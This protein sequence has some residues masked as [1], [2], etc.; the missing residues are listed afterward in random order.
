MVD[1]SAEFG[2]LTRKL[3]GAPPGIGGNAEE[4]PRGR[5]RQRD[6]NPA[7]QT[8]LTG[9]VYIASELESLTSQ[10]NK[11]VAESQGQINMDDTGAALAQ[12]TKSKLDKLDKAIHG[13]KRIVESSNSKQLRQHYD[14]IHKILSSRFGVQTKRFQKTLEKRTKAI[15][16]K[17][18]QQVKRFGASK[19]QLTAPSASNFN[20]SIHRMGPNGPRSPHFGP[21]PGQGVPGR[22][23]GPRPTSGAKGAESG[24]V[25]GESFS[26]RHT[27]D[28]GAHT[29]GYGQGAGFPTQPAVGPGGMRRR[30]QASTNEQSSNHM[31][32]SNTYMARNHVPTFNPYS[33]PMMH[34]KKN[35]GLDG[36]EQFGARQTAQYARA[37]MEQRRKALE[38]QNVESMMSDLSQMFARVG[39]LVAEQ[40][41]EVDRIDDNLVTAGVDIQAG[42]NEL[43]KY[44]NN[45]SQE[46][47]LIIKILLV[48]LFL[49]MFFI[50]WWR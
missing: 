13:L 16:A 17:Q 23:L 39:T 37:T 34:P 45:M 8:F 36:G 15:S 30:G 24:F 1:R 31:N 7:N 14:I 25:A 26:E 32:G 50:Y 6:P 27:S 5:V 2:A 47:A 42:Q 48:T 20:R 40:G 41:E 35:D 22:G 43:L 38:M 29:P 49:G 3:G 46:R 33:D 19:V 21:T 18:A 12:E 10:V 44:Y 9:S 4:D 28:S 11:F